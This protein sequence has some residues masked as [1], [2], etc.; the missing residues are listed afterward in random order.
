[1]QR[2]IVVMGVSGCGKSTLGKALAGRLDCLFI[3]ADDHHS[4]SNV[5]KMSSG[6]PLTDADRADWVDS[7]VTRLDETD[8]ADVVLA[9]SALTPFVQSR[10]LSAKNRR[11][12]WLYL[13]VSKQVLTERMNAR[14]HFMPASL[15]DS[16]FDALSVPENAIELDGELEFEALIAQ[17]CQHLG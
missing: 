10:L 13:A 6:V 5:E 11:V 17:V 8:Q 15:L 9:C 1:V 12:I 4:A 16:Q 3:E 14:E 7:I 2:L